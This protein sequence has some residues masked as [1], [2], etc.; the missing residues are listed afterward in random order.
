MQAVTTMAEE[1]P[2]EVAAE[3]G[4]FG[5]AV[6]SEPESP[7][8]EESNGSVPKKDRRQGRSRQARTAC[9]RKPASG[10]NTPK[11]RSRR[12]YAEE[13]CSGGQPTV[14]NANGSEEQLQAHA[15][16]R[17]DNFREHQRRHHLRCWK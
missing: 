11:P 6:T 8:H 7:G 10:P 3:V 17:L 14:S 2:Q 15:K 12:K 5:D 13:N 4:M 16:S 9:N 1:K